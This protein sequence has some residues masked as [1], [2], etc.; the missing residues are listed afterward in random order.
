[1][2]E[3]E[4]ANQ[5]FGVLP[6]DAQQKFNRIWDG[7][8]S[9]IES[10]RGPMNN[11][12]LLPFV[13]MLVR[14]FYVSGYSSALDAEKVRTAATRQALSEKFASYMQGTARNR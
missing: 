14:L 4:E 2:T 1:M 7:I 13:D 6:I 10:R 9:D 11:P 5:I 3:L 12:E 8:L